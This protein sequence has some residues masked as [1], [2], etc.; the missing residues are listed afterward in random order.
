M[1]VWITIT[2]FDL[3]KNAILY[4]SQNRFYEVHKMDNS[5]PL[6]EESNP[7]PPGALPSELKLIKACE[8]RTHDNPALYRLSYKGI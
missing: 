4:T 2:Y 3:A 6:S 8:T 1:V 5:S 7:R